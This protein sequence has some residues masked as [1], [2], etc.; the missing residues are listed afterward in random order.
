MLELKSKLLFSH[1]TKRIETIEGKLK[2]VKITF[3]NR[4]FQKNNIF[5][6]SSS[7]LCTTP[8]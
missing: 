3:S 1:K 2:I 7:A 6:P 4:V 5:P 8:Q